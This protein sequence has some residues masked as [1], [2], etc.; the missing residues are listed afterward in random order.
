MTT[1]QE[2]RFEIGDKVYI[3]T[4]N[5]HGKV[6]NVNLSP[7]ASRG[8]TYTVE[9]NNTSGGGPGSIGCHEDSMVKE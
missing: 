3:G 2:P 8:Y 4:M 9:F 7:I 6:V 5:I 1:A